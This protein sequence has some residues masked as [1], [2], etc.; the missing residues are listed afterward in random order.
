[1]EDE[2]EA[3]ARL[4]ETRRR[5]RDATHNVY[6]YLIREGNLMRYSD[7]GEP[8]GTSGLPVLGV[9]R[10]EKLQNVCC[11]VT[12]YFGGTLLGTG[13]LV[14][15]YSHAAKIALDAAG[16]AEMAMWVRTEIPCSYAM[17]EPVR[18]ELERSGALILDTQFSQRVELTAMLREETAEDFARRL[19]DLTAGRIQAEFLPGEFRGVRIK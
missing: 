7:D 12:R 16:I 15:A 5:H 19:T 13:G 10:G 1:M 3:L 4:E 8:Q 9:F 17:Y 14:R 2:A 11:V 18:S 6:A